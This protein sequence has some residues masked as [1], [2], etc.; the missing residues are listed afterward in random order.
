MVGVEVVM[1]GW[2]RRYS[3]RLPSRLPIQDTSLILLSQK[4]AGDCHWESVN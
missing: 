1:M 4:V 3:S 2:R